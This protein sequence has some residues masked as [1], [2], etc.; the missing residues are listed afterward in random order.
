MVRRLLGSGGMGRSGLEGGG[1]LGVEF[2]SRD[3]RLIGVGEVGY[4]V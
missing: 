3:E 4:E 1:G 2:G